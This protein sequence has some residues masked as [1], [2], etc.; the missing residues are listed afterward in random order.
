MLPKSISWPLQLTPF[1]WSMLDSVAGCEMVFFVKLQFTGAIDRDLFQNA[2]SQAIATQPLLQSN[3]AIGDGFRNCYWV[4]AKHPEIEIEWS[5]ND[6]DANKAFDLSKEIGLKIRG[7]IEG[8]KIQ[9]YF[10]FHHACCDGIGGIRFIEQILSNYHQALNP[11]DSVRHWRPDPELLKIRNPQPNINSRLRRLQRSAWVLPKRIFRIMFKKPVSITDSTLPVAEQENLTL[12]TRVLTEQQTR[13]ITRKASE[14]DV[15]RNELLL[16]DLLL[17]IRKFNDIRSSNDRQMQHRPFRVML[18]ISTRSRE[19]KNMP[20]AN[21]V[22]MVA[23]E[24]QDGQL[25]RPDETMSYLKKQMEFVGRWQIEYSWSQT[26]SFLTSLPFLGSLLNQ[27][28]SPIRATGVF[29]NAGRIFK[30]NNLPRVDGKIRAGNMVLESFHASPP[31]NQF[32]PVTFSCNYYANRLTLTSN[33]NHRM[34][35]RADA[36]RLF[37]L[38]LDQ[39]LETIHEMP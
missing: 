30:N 9:L 24:I 11:E 32:V 23:I 17:A 25:D 1:E 16:R 18:P 29:S 26:I 5:S 27:R 14:F 4:A 3:L 21:C 37:Q 19:H 15:G 6:P 20:A 8:D 39:I 35:T 7:R 12:P 2:V 38:W 13:S 33:F 22:S 31:G 34:L 10:L 36:E 28:S